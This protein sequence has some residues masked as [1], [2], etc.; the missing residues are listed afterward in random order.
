MFIQ[1]VNKAKTWNAVM[2]AT[3]LSW[4]SE[5]FFK[6]LMWSDKAGFHF[7][8]AGSFTSIIAVTPKAQ[9]RRISQGLR[10]G[11]VISPLPRSV[12]VD[13]DVDM[14]NGGRGQEFHSQINWYLS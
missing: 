11:Y 6:K 7:G 13:V 4:H 2:M 14:D 3:L 1:V 10:L 8:F 12:I 9:V 5:F